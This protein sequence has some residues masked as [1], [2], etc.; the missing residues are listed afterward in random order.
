MPTKHQSSCIL[1]VVLMYNLEN[2]HSVFVFQMF[3]FDHFLL[4]FSGSA[5]SQN[6]GYFS[7]M[8]L[9]VIYI[10]VSGIYK[11]TWSGAYVKT[12]MYNN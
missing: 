11:E 8:L 9:A 6:I 7:L 2:V 12:K 3:Y 4:S 10:K 5:I 1:K